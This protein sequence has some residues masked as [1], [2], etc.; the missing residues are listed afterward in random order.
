MPTITLEPGQ[1]NNRIDPIQLGR[2]DVKT[3]LLTNL[4]IAENIIFDDA[5]KV[6]RREGRTSRHSGATHSLKTP[7]NEGDYTY[8]VEGGVLKQFEADY[9]VSTI[10][11]LRSDLP[12]YYEPVNQE[13]VASNGVDIGWLLSNSYTAFSPTLTDEFEAAMPA[14]QFL[15]FYKGTLYVAA[16]SVIYASKPYN[17][18]VMDVRY[19]QIPLDGAIRMLASVEDGL[20]VATDNRVVFLDGGGVDEFVYR[21]K[22]DNSPP[23]GAFDVSWDDTEDGVRKVVSWVSK[24]G[25]CQGRAGGAY[26]NLSY[27]NIALPPGESGV[28]LRRVTN[29]IEQTIAV[30]RKPGDSDAFT[31]PTLTINSITVT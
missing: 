22:T 18:E 10:A 8:F 12:L 4:A 31:A 19:S 25:M 5:G 28:C 15:A 26:K 23:N 24:E 3:R 11:T 16:G 2:V 30:I 20:W 1:L 21:E 27:P 13:V 29:G 17:I 6:T 14:G 9:S 7:Q